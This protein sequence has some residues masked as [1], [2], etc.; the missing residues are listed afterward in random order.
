MMNKMVEC[1]RK[2]LR[3]FGRCYLLIP[4]ERFRKATEDCCHCR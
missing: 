4:M 2:T 1:G 3:L